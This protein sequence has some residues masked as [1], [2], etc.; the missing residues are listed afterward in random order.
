L[1]RKNQAKYKS[2]VMVPG[3]LFSLLSILRKPPGV[4]E[5]K[6]PYSNT[7]TTPVLGNKLPDPNLPYSVFK[8]GYALVM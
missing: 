1:S 6:N 2:K 8:I 3:N 7:I 5:K 4:K